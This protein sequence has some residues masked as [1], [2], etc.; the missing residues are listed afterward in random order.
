MSPPRHLLV[1]WDEIHHRVRRADRVA[2]F[3]DFDGTLAAISRWP[4]RVR[5]AP[6]VR[7][8]LA[9]IAQ[10]NVTLGVV[11]G[12]RLVDV[13]ARVGLRGIWY[14]GAHGYFLCEPG[15][16]SATLLTATSIAQMTLVRRRLARQLHGMP[17][18]ILEHKEA[19]AAVHYRNASPGIRELA[20]TAIRRLLENHPNLHLLSG[21]KVWELLPDTRTNKWTAIRRI[22]QTERQRL[23]GR[24]VVFY[25]GDDATDE[26][27]FEKMKGI[28]VAVGRSRRTAARYFLRSPA[29][30][31]QFLERFCEVVR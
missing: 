21:K 12:R 28:S 24:W 18:I 17:G 16:K 14:V 31:R 9:A 2:L 26:R 8:L 30:V 15:G 27:V 4:S 3:T 10:K 19:T 13:Q 25:L 23:S 29:E 7:A 22:L 20:F 1:V 11:S 5:L 6:R